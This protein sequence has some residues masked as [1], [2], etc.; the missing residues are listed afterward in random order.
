MQKKDYTGAVYKYKLHRLETVKWFGVWTWQIEGPGNAWH[1]IGTAE[2]AT[3]GE[4]IQAGKV[5]IVNQRLE[6]GLVT[7]EQF[8]AEI[9]EL[10]DGVNDQQKGETVC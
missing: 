1:I 7:A 9:S 2:Y 10:Q 8:A 5:E 6:S 3:E 4:A